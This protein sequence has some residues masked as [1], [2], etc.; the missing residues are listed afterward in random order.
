M[1]ARILREAGILLAVSLAPA[2]IS[3]MTLINLREAGL[4]QPVDPRLRYR[5]E[6]AK[7]EV[8]VEQAKG[9]KSVLW[10]DARAEASYEAGHIS[11]A[12]QLNPEA[13]DGE[14][15]PFLEH[16]KADVPTVVYCDGLQCGRSYVVAG[17]LRLDLGLRNVYVLRGGWAAWNG[18]P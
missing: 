13:W 15:K 14:I 16:W 10:V 18:K 9:W 7:Y 17:R 12:V 11:G 1:I 2:V 3:S 5:D 4:G 6:A 8:T